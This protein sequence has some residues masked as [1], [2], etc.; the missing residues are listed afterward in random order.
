MSQKECQKARSEVLYALEDFADKYET[1]CER[2]TEA[3]EAAYR[4]GF[5]DARSDEENEV[6]ACWKASYAKKAVDE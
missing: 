5:E 4:E 1:E 3:I 2:L 6:N